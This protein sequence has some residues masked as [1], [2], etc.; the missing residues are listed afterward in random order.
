M[1]DS[2]VDAQ[3]APADCENCGTPLQGH[4]CHECGQSIHS[5]TRNFGHALEEVFESFWHLD[6]RVF[7]SMRDLMVPGRIARNYLE[8]KRARYIAPLR[9]FV[10]MSLLTFFVGK[11]VVHLDGKPVQFDGEGSA[12]IRHAQ[13]VDEVRRLEAS[14]LKSLAAKEA[15]AAK[16]PGVDAALIAA[17][18]AIQGEAANRIVQIEAEEKKRAAGSAPGST[19][20]A[21]PASGSAKNDAPAPSPGKAGVAA[22]PERKHAGFGMDDEEWRFNGKPWNEKTNPVDVPLMPGFVDRWFN[23]KIARA[24]SNLEHMESPNEFVQAALGAVPTALF[25]LMPIFAL[26]L[27]VLYL[28]SGRRYLEHLVVALYSHAWLLFAILTMFVMNAFDDAAGDKGWVPI[29]TSL[30][31]AAIW[32][33]IPIYLFLMQHRIYGDHWALTAVR[34]L[35]IGSIYMVLVLCVVLFAVLAGIVA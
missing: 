4:F 6:G 19:A 9:L 18:A 12:A 3:H 32:I 15:E 23:R 34:Y 20:A 28:G 8:G 35:V 16:V 31:D 5:P 17:R 33:W 29:V 10:I 21:T 27:K 26:L 1:S 30:V 11:L 13:T 2:D 22:P 7:R 24:R 14:Q 25:V